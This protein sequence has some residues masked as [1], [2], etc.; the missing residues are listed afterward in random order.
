VPLGRF[1]ALSA[2]ATAIASSCGPRPTRAAWLKKASGV[3]AS[4]SGKR[5]VADEPARAQLDDGLEDRHDRLGALQ[6]LL[7]LH[8]LGA[9][10]RQDADLV[11]VV[12]LGA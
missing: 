9:H 3:R 6:Q 7:D 5:V 10:R 2:A 1:G 8:A 12:L 4:W 11:G